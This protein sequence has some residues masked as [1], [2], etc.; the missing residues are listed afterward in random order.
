MSG[1]DTPD[2]DDEAA[3]ER[4]QRRIAD[5]QNRGGQPAPAPSP[6]PL[7]DRGAGSPDDG[8]RGRRDRDAK[9]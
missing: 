4:L 9:G 2:T 3:L 5:L 1:P 7:A 6:G 8:A